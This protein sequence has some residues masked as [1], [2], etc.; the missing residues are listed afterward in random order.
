MEEVLGGSDIVESLAVDAV[1]ERLAGDLFAVACDHVF[2]GSDGVGECAVKRS[3]DLT[4][5]GVWIGLWRG[6]DV[7]AGNVGKLFI[8]TARGVVSFGQLG[9]A[10]VVME[11][12]AECGFLNERQR[13]EAVARAVDESEGNREEFET[14]RALLLVSGLFLR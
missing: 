14:A 5:D 9:I 4:F 2:D 13:R 12:C 11:D 3:D 6:E 7:V 8:E 10:E 1:G